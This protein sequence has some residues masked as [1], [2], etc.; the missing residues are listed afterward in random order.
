MPLIVITGNPCSGKTTRSLELKE[1]FERRLKSDGQNVEIISESDAIIK[2]G[3]DKNVF[4]AG[5]SKSENVKLV[6]D[7]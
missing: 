7:T 6:H 4:Y 1:Y 2:A 5:Q 3:Y